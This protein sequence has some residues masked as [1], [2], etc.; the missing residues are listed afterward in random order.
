[1]TPAPASTR[2]GYRVGLVRRTRRITGRSSI[3]PATPTAS[4]IAISSDE[5]LE[6]D[7]ERAALL[8]G[9]LDH[10]DHQRDP[11]RVVGAGFAL[12]DRSCSA[13]DLAA[14]EHGERD[15]RIRRGDRRADQSGHDPREAEEVMPDERDETRGGERA[16]DAESENR[17]GG[18][19]KARDAD[20]EAAVEEDDDQRDDADALDGLD[21]QGV[22][23]RVHRRREDARGDE[24][25]ARRWGARSGRRARIPSTARKTPAE[26][27]RTTVPK[28][29]IS[30][31]SGTWES[32]A[33]G[34]WRERSYSL[35]TGF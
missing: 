15:R 9:E 19:S 12:E 29:E 27:T 18:A 30:V 28:S 4:P 24:E 20:V 33:P 14:A 35:L 34:P 7:R 8:G 32:T 22:A 26:T 16:D 3:A 23:Q 10:P 13:A 25:E 2:T 5:L 31:T 11:D 1:M 21:G 6:H 17:P